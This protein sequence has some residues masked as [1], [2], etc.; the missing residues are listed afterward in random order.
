M[1]VL[2]DEERFEAK[3]LHSLSYLGRTNV[4]QGL[5]REPYAIE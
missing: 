5:R 2:T 1:N 3:N 4:S